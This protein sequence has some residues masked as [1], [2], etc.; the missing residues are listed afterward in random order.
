MNEIFANCLKIKK[1]YKKYFENWKKFYKFVIL[2]YIRKKK[3]WQN[4]KLL[5]KN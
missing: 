5:A 4:N 2:K 3:K 1:N